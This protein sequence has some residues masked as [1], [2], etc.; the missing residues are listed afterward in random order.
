M[1]RNALKKA[2]QPQKLGYQSGDPSPTPDDEPND[3]WRE[4]LGQTFAYLVIA[5]LT[6]ALAFLAAAG[7]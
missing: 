1:H 7:C 3:V 4:L 5:A 2:E 6:I